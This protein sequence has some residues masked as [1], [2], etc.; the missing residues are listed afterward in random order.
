MSAELVIHTLLDADA[1]LNALVADRIYSLTRPEGDALPA[2]VHVEITDLPRPPI[3][4]TTGSE[5]MIGRIQ[6]NCLARTS[7]AVRQIKEAVIAA[8][9]KQSGSI[10]GITVEAVLQDPAGPRSYD[11]LVDTCQQSVDFIVHYIR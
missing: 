7:N 8:C 2:V 3:D 1:G 11:A 5:P 4:A 6:V 10:G 9:H